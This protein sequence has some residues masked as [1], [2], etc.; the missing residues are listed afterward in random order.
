MLGSTSALQL[1]T[2]LNC[3]IT[4]EKHQ[5]NAKYVALNS[6]QKGSL[7]TV[8][9]AEIRRWNLDLSWECACRVTLQLC[10]CACPQMT[11]KVPQV[12]ILEL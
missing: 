10:A 5:K 2:I 3:K 6:P 9:R 12:L 4:N 8:M 7:F 11:M 1:G